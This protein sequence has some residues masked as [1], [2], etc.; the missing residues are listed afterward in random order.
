MLLVKA[1][2]VIR[3]ID[4]INP[5]RESTSRN[6]AIPYAPIAMRRR[7]KASPQAIAISNEIATPCPTTAVLF[8]YRRSG[9]PR[10]VPDLCPSQRVATEGC[11][12]SDL[13]GGSAGC[14]QF[15]NSVVG[16]FCAMYERKEPYGE[17]MAPWRDG[18]NSSVGLRWLGQ[19]Q[20]R[21]GAR[22]R[23]W[24]CPSGAYPSIDEAPN[25]LHP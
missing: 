4:P 13:H 7:I 15:A 17:H 16:P 9:G 14:R 20:R 6:R 18:I 24:R 23:T 5:F 21:P 22:S 1:H 3:R 11:S 2:D 10:P 19:T 12:A 8:L 25:R